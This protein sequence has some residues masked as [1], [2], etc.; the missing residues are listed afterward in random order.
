MCWITDKIPVKEIA[1]EDIKVYKIINT[2]CGLFSPCIPDISWEIGI[3]KYSEIGVSGH[4]IREGLYSLKDIPH[5]EPQH[6]WSNLLS[7]LEWVTAEN[8]SIMKYDYGEKV[9][10][11]IIPAGSEYYLNELGEYVSNQLILTKEYLLNIE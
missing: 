2:H 8:K 5:I 10:E 3:P 11:A 7:Y 9:F 1:K 6:G 4:L